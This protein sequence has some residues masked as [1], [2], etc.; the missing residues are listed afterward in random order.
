LAFITF[1][2]YYVI[3]NSLNFNKRIK[4]KHAFVGTII[5]WIIALVEASL[6]LFNLNSYSAYA[7][8][9]PFDTR[10]K[11]F[12]AYAISLEMLLI[13]CLFFICTFY[14]LIILNNVVMERRMSLNTCNDN[15]QLRK[16]EAE[17]QKM[18][19]K[20][21]ILILANIICWG[22]VVYLCTHSLANINIMNR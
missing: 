20:I 4:F 11:I 18:A 21:S 5:I 2:R 8:C 9:L 3:K 14:L 13:I 12:H 15:N 16:R 1:E 7:I 17:D 22:P 19:K 10:N 6:P